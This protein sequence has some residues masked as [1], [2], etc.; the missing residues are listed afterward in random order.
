MR[1]NQ[2]NPKCSNIFDQHIQEVEKLEDEIHRKQSDFTS[3]FSAKIS[4]SNQSS[5]FHNYDKSK[6]EFVK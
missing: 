6:D 4:N 5:I 3:K 1:Y 2:F